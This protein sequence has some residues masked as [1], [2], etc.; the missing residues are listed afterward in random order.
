MGEPDLHKHISPN[1]QD[2]RRAYI[3]KVNPPK[4]LRN[5]FITKFI[6]VLAQLCRPGWA[7]LNW[8]LLALASEGNLWLLLTRS[9]F[10]EGTSTTAKTWSDWEFWRLFLWDFGGRGGG[11]WCHPRQSDT[12]QLGSKVKTREVLSSLR[13]L[14]HHHPWARRF[15]LWSKWGLFHDF[16]SLYKVLSVILW[17]LLTWP[18]CVAVTSSFLFALHAGSF[19]VWA[20]DC[21]SCVSVKYLKREKDFFNRLSVLFPTY[22]SLSSV[23]R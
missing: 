8:H 7:E 15:S 19:G 5:A 23:K 6:H 10:T 22:M 16:V 9:C 11:T 2:W 14:V 1:Y 21:V 20:C 3:I 17:L 13:S 4:Q 18:S 12:N